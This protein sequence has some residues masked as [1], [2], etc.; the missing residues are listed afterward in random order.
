MTDEIQHKSLP[1]NT[2]SIGWT[3]WLFE[4]TVLEPAAR[5]FDEGSY[6]QCFSKSLILPVTLACVITSIKT[7]AVGLT[8]DLE[9]EIAATSVDAMIGVG[10]AVMAQKAGS[11]LSSWLSKNCQSFFGGQVGPD[12]S[13]PGT[14]KIPH[15]GALNP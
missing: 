5:K 1:S 13:Q 8:S 4:G 10:G 11:V 9:N 7:E 3:L 12:G 14:D 15:Y 2:T 6:N